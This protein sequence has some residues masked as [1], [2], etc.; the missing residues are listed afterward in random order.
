MSRG[1]VIFAFRRPIAAKR[2]FE[3]G[4]N[5]PAKAAGAPLRRIGRE[6]ARIGDII[7]VGGE[8]HAAF[9]KNQRPP[10]RIAETPCGAR[11]WAGA[12]T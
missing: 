7:L 2:I 6:F 9:H 12:K 11:E 4:A 8:G 10:K 5:R 3:A 1:I